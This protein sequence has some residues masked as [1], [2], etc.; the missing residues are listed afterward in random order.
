MYYTDHIGEVK[1][2]Q[3]TMSFY[4]YFS[5]KVLNTF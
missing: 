1:L 4:R 5:I 2:G 3:V